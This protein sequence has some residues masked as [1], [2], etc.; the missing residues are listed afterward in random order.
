MIP[1][2]GVL[3]LEFVYFDLRG[4]GLED[5]SSPVGG[6]LDPFVGTFSFFSDTGLQIVHIY[7]YR[8]LHLR[9]VW[10]TIPK[11]GFQDP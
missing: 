8:L 11:Y 9:F 7:L 2:T 3:S 6:C 5:S 10:G 1:S 4:K